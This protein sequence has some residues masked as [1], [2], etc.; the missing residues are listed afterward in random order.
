MANF[1]AGLD[2]AQTADWS[3]LVVAE[4]VQRHAGMRQWRRDRAD[5]CYMTGEF[6]EL[7]DTFRVRHIQRWRGSAYQVVVN[8]VCEVLS[9]PPLRGQ[10]ALVLDETGVGRPVRD[11]F[12]QARREG[13]LL[14]WP[15]GLTITGGAEESYHEL[16]PGV[17]L[18]QIRLGPPR[19]RSVP[20][21]LLVQRLE[22][23]LQQGRV[24]VSDGLVLAPALREELL[25]FQGQTGST[26][27]VRFEAGAGHDDLVLGTMLAVY[28]PVETLGTPS[29][30]DADGVLWP[31]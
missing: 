13:R 25:A 24:Q 18:G 11:L 7:E 27:H 23:L 20:K 16:G 4:H 5:G 19:L 8:Q 10:V 29:Y 30:I 12:D 17:G 22:V 6:E 2:L 26:G 31:R 3:A 15:L 21:H 9:R 1:V 28:P 14:R